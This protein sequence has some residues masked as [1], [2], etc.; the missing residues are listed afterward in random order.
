LHGKGGF[1]KL[2]FL[3]FLMTVGFGMA[4]NNGLN[5]LEGLLK[6]SGEFKRT[7]KRGAGKALLSSDP[8]QAWQSIL[9]IGLSFYTLLTAALMWRAGEGLSTGV[10]LIY[11]IGFALAGWGTL[12][13]ALPQWVARS[14]L[15]QT[16]EQ[17]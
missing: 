2:L 4:F 11:T 9:E 13:S 17:E 6:R 8:R 1:R 14:H 5:V 3:P 12:G 7:P 10:L 16:Q 15:P